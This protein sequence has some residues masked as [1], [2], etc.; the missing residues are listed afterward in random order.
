MFFLLEVREKSNTLQKPQLNFFLLEV[1]VSNPFFWG[2][3][4][5]RRVASF[6]RQHPYENKSPV[7][8]I[9]VSNVQ[10]FSLQHPPAMNVNLLVPQLLQQQSSFQAHQVRLQQQMAE[11]QVRLQQQMAEQ[12]QRFQHQLF[13]LLFFLLRIVHI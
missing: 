9:N 1:S 7:T 4:N 3:F 5:L 11:Q 6:P 2:Q 13:N 10:N 8:Q 12:Q